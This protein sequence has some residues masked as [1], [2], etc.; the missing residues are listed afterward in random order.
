[1]GAVYTNLHLLLTLFTEGINS[2]ILDIKVRENKIRRQNKNAKNKGENHNCIASRSDDINNHSTRKRILR[3]HTDQLHR[4]N[5]TIAHNTST[6]R[7]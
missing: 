3:K 2:N 1:M 6:R 4:T 7:R 5:S